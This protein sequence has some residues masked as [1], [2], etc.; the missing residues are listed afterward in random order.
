MLIEDCLSKRAVLRSISVT[1]Q[2]LDAYKANV[3]VAAAKTLTVSLITQPD[4]LDFLEKADPLW[5]NILLEIPEGKRGVSL[6]DD[7]LARR[8]CDKEVGMFNEA[9][10]RQCLSKF[11]GDPDHHLRSPYFLLEIPISQYQLKQGELLIAATGDPDHIDKL[12]IHQTLSG[13]V[14]SDASMALSEALLTGKLALPNEGQVYGQ[15]TL[16]WLKTQGWES[17]KEKAVTLRDKARADARM[18]LDKEKARK[19]TLKPHVPDNVA[20]TSAGAR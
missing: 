7:M 17:V 5:K 11:G 18:L 6:A 10:H 16:D 8:Y 14:D 12:V 9:F 19:E 15:S 13:I 3:F 20:Q 4:F 1:P 2:Q